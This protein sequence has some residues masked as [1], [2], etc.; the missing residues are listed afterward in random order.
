[1]RPGALQDPSMSF[2]RVIFA[3]PKH[4]GNPQLCLPEDCGLKVLQ[5]ELT[6]IK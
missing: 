4:N 5:W 6:G 2:N 3:Q 1:M